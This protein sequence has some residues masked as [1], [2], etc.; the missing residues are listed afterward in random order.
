MIID[1]LDVLSAGICPSETHPKLIVD[2]DAVLSFP[3]AFKSFQ[4]IPGRDAKV[5]QSP[6]DFQLSKLT[7]SHRGK[8]GK[9]LCRIALG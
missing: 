4:S 6:R 1:D 8:I 5:F 9:S 2:P 3:F 7:S